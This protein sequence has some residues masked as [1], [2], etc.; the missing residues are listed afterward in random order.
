MLR[1][2]YLTS[3]YPAPSH[4]FIA[5]EVAELRRRGF[6]V[7]TFSVRPLDKPSTGH[8]PTLRLTTCFLFDH[9]CTPKPW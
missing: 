9:V 3:Q 8:K 2:G 1:I 7:H 4:T 6:E 5:R